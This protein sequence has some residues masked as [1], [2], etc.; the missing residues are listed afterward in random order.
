MNT[1]AP[2]S[3]EVKCILCNG[4]G[5]DPMSDIVN[6]LP[7]APCAGTGLMLVTQH[8]AAKNEEFKT[9]GIMIAGGIT[10]ERVIVFDRILDTIK[11]MGCEAEV[12]MGGELHE[13]IQGDPDFKVKVSIE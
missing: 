7:C 11:E 6:W 2:Q 4:T 12:R 5:A 8:P 13:I 9:I 3:R 1:S 10:W